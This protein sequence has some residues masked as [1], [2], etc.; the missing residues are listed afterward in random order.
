MIDEKVER[1]E[2]EQSLFLALAKKKV[3]TKITNELDKKAKDLIQSALPISVD[4]LQ[5]MILARG[6]FE[7]VA[8]RFLWKLKHDMQFKDADKTLVSGDH[9][10]LCRKK[11][12][13]MNLNKR[14]KQ[15]NDIAKEMKKRR[16]EERELDGETDLEG[17][18]TE[19]DTEV[20]VIKNSRFIDWESME[21]ET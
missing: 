6:I 13:L 4:Q 19:S 7:T 17:A 9:H 10:N 12:K 20:H 21:S 15:R 16:R 8:I 5:E 18:V 14:C 2:F 3:K 1:G 11:V